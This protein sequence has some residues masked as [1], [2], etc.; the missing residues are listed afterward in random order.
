VFVRAVAVWHI[1]WLVNSAAHLWGYR[2]YKTGQDSRNSWVVAIAVAGW[3]NHHH[4]SALCAAWHRQYEVDLVFG[5]IR[6]LEAIGL[7][8]ELSLPDPRVIASLS[9]KTRSL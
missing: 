1:T 5:F 2:N 7:A 3:H 9:D 4:G 6:M 8:S